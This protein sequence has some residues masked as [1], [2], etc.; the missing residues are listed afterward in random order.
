MDYVQR[1]T[2]DIHELTD[3]LL[4][5]EWFAGNPS[6]FLFIEIDSI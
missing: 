2:R 1:N 4:V 5:A 6:G 3:R